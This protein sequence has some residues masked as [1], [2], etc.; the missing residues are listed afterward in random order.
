MSGASLVAICSD[1]LFWL[2]VKE[3]TRKVEL[4]IQELPLRRSGRSVSHGPNHWTRR[5]HADAIIASYDNNI[6]L[7]LIANI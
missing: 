6:Q 7:V 3:E 2:K 4:F 5:I 1:Q